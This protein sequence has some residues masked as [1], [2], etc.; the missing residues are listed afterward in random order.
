MD[1]LLIVITIVEVG[2]EDRV[3]VVSIVSDV[4]AFGSW[5]DFIS[6]GGSG[7]SRSRACCC[8]KHQVVCISS[9]CSDASSSERT[10]LVSL[11]KEITQE[12]TARFTLTDDSRNPDGSVVNSHR[13]DKESSHRVFLCKV[14]YRIIVGRHSITT[15]GSSFAFFS[16]QLLEYAFC[17]ML[18]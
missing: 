13:K 5:L 11:T 2:E 12:V 1:R 17:L 3:V 14:Q 18:P 10:F 9:F 15:V 4:S 16:Q 8:S 6:N 7:L